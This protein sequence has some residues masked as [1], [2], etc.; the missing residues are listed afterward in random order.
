MY[1]DRFRY[2]PIELDIWGREEQ[3]TSYYGTLRTYLP[4]YI[5]TDE[6]RMGKFLN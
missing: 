2:D 4:A 1:L 3:A 5:P 6:K